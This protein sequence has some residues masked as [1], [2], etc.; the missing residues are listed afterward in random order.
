MLTSSISSQDGSQKVFYTPGQAIG[1]HKHANLLKMIAQIALGAFALMV[2]F[3]I[4]SF[5]KM[6]LTMTPGIVFAAI[7]ITTVFFAAV[8]YIANSKL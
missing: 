8:A 5:A 7:G 4:L 1:Y 6:S 2:S 3:S